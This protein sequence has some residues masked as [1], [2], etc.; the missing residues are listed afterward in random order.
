MTDSKGG[1][2]SAED[3]DSLIEKGRPEHAEGAFY[4]WTKEEIVRALGED[5][6]A[7]FNRVYGMEEDGNAPA[8]SDPQGEFRGKNILIQRLSIADAAKFFRKSEGDLTASLVES[9]KKLLA[10]RDQRPR[11]HLDDKII[12]AWNGL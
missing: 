6:A 8:G 1:F 11:P 5:D 3:A 10:L 12:T 4:V 9:R 7:L 2:Y